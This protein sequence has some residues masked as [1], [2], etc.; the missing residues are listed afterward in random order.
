[1]SEDILFIIMMRMIINM[2]LCKAGLNS[3][4]NRSW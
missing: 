1:M 2:E 4:F 3:K